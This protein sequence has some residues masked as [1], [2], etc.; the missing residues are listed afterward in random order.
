MVEEI[1]MEFNLFDHFKNFGKT[2]MD[3]SNPYEQGTMFFST[4]AAWRAHVAAYG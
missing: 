1:A 3:A 2:P 4:G